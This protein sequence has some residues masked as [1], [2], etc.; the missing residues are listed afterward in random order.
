[1]TDG[2]EEMSTQ[3]PVTTNYD[4]ACQLPEVHAAWPIVG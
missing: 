3:S 4:L 1:M 2:K